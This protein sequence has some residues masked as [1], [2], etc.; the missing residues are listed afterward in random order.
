MKDPNVRAKLK[1]VT[2]NAIWQE[3]QLASTNEAQMPSIES[4]QQSH[5]SSSKKILLNKSELRRHERRRSEI[6]DKLVETEMKS[7]LLR[8]AS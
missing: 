1:Q 3:L 2:Y 7:M 5:Q 8:N 4:G 6:R